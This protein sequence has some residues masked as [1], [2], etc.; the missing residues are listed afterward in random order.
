VVLVP[1]QDWVALA[2]AELLHL[3]G[4]VANELSK[5]ASANCAPYPRVN[6]TLR[7]R[8]RIRGS[9]A[10]RGGTLLE[11]IR[12]AVK[13]AALDERFGD[14]LV[15]G[16]LHD[17]TIELWLQ[18]AASPIPSECRK[19]PE[20]IIPGVDGL[21]VEFGSTCAYYKP[22][23]WLTSGVGSAAELFEKLCLK[24]G[25]DPNAWLDPRCALRKTSWTH[26]LGPRYSPAVE[27][28]ALRCV[29][30][31]EPSERIMRRWAH[32]GARFLTHNQD[33]CGWYLYTYFPLDGRCETKNRQQ[34]HG[35][36]KA[37]NLVRAAGCTY[38]MAWMA[39]IETCPT[40]RD[41]W[42]GSA[43]RAADAL[44]ARAVRFG[45]GLIIVEDDPSGRKW[46]KLGS[47]ALL[48]VAL[49]FPSLN[50]EFA[51][52]YRGLMTTVIG[53][54]GS[55]GMFQCRFG[56]AENEPA[57]VEFY[58]GEA[59]LALALAGERGD[60]SA[61]AIC[62]RAFSAYCQ[63]FREIPRSSFVLWQVDVWS[64]L[65]IIEND[66]KI[67]DFVFEMV[68]WLLQFQVV[69][70]P[71]GIYHGGF[72]THGA[73]GASTCTYTEAVI[74]GAKV[75]RILGDR[76]RWF[77]YRKAMMAATSFCARL[78]IC[79]E[80]RPFLADPARAFGGVT[81]S[82]KSFDVR[83]DHVQHLITLA[84]TSLDE[85]SLFGSDIERGR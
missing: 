20:I 13:R 17:L 43:R 33:A 71:P 18:T 79:K 84:L 1:N 70:R 45:D 63:H 55:N 53:S 19:D 52:A 73:P 62:H 32:D 29:V 46:G 75:A 44:L 47:V 3:F 61:L 40:R 50:E 14:R 10:G 23:V 37:T 41:R 59:L 78:V 80:Q 30:P 16:E 76:D 28:V 35:N 36:A 6:V 38:A 27:L 82:L 12:N 4:V 77:R 24:A 39:S 74:R 68:D 25:L 58:P 42:R 8:G 22:S 11:Q 5:P 2:W 49:S 72:A 57:E 81:R 66:Q 21:E 65:A 67:A 31:S 56:S 34:F 54:Q 60:T 26:F 9:M 83:C 51:E 48:A 15:A 64:R 85:P 69:E 7:S